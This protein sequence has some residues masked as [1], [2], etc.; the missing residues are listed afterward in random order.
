MKQLIIGLVIVMFGLAG[1]G[2]HSELQYALQSGTVLGWN[3]H[4]YKIVKSINPD[5]AGEK[6]GNVTY[7]GKVSGT[8]TVLQLKGQRPSKSIIFESL[9]GQYFQADVESNNSK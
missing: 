1:C 8:F 6:L 7:H 3:N 4:L 2:V 9:T 5:A